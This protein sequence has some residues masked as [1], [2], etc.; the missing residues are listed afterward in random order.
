MLEA[1]MPDKAYQLFKQ[2]YVSGLE[3]PVDVEIIRDPMVP[4][5]FAVRVTINS[6][7]CYRYRGEDKQIN[8][9]EDYCLLWSAD[10]WEEAEFESWPPTSSEEAMSD[11]IFS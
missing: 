10:D 11:S 2:Y 4:E 9:T 6:T 3:D 5:A 1:G 8:Y 7:V